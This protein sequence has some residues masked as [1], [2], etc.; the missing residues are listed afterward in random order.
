MP[1]WY[2]HLDVAKKAIAA[3]NEKGQYFDG[4]GPTPPSIQAIAEKNP[5][6]FALGAIGPD[7][8][9]MLPDFAPPNDWIRGTA[10]TIFAI[11]DWIDEYFIGPYEK[12][13]EP[14]MMSG[15]SELDAFTGGLWGT[16][17]S[18]YSDFSRNVTDLLITELASQYDL[19][20][21][22]GS[23]VP[24]G[25]DE[26]VYYWSDILHYR[27]TYTFGAHLWQKASAAKDSSL[28]AFALGWM[29][30]LAADVTGHCFVNEKCGGPYRL[31]WQ[32]H[33]LVENHMDATVY[34]HEHGTGNQYESLT[35]SALHLWINFDSSS[36]TN[37]FVSSGPSYPTGDDVNSM[38]ARQRAWDRDSSLPDV[39]AQFICQALLDVYLTSPTDPTALSKAAWA[40]HP[41][42]LPGDPPG[43]PAGFPTP[44]DLFDPSTGS[45]AYQYLYKYLKWTSTAQYR[46]PRPQPPAKYVIPEFPAFP[47]SGSSDPTLDGNWA[48]DVIAILLLL[49]AWALW[50][51]EVLLYPLA[52][53]AALIL[54]PLT[55]DLRRWI[56]D[57][58]QVPSYNLWLALHWFHSL[59]GYELP[60]NSEINPGLTTLG[61]SV[62][63]LEATL[64]A[65][66]DDPSG[67]LST[68]VPPTASE[69]SGRDLD[70]QF[71]R[72]AMTDPNTLVQ[73]IVAST[74]LGH[75]CSKLSES[76]S[77]FARPWQFPLSDNAGDTMPSELPLTVA[78][79]YRSGVDAT[80]LFA[81]QP[82][83]AA[84]RTTFE[85]AGSSAETDKAAGAFL[86][87]GQHLGDPV[88]YTCYL[89]GKLTRD[90]LDPESLAS[91]NLDSD[92]GYGY[93]CWDWVRSHY[94]T[95]TPSGYAGTHAHDYQAPQQPGY[96]WCADEL[97]PAAAPPPPGTPIPAS[98]DPTKPETPVGIRYIGKEVR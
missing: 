69:P 1:G 93:L 14:V 96:G 67:G 81:N 10:K 28:Q 30:H 78:S 52:V 26:K 98:H 53:G 86:P 49:L 46:F 20:G 13:I 37:F 38:L 39:L 87:H 29:T 16:I 6:Y 66:L 50:L 17:S 11:Y 89:I 32:R 63:D 47:G 95:G 72:D 48:H 59:T 70:T 5:A 56:Y 57:H 76:P 51:I 97:N 65:V 9:F 82:G 74:P 58:F 36:A 68:T 15:S 91:F 85:N 84:A 62:G 61:T 19:F 3:L 42:I 7:L 80:V 75:T 90:G 94:Y 35:E 8:F 60:M 77:E 31:H 24:K 44:G 55:F 4:A 73:S 18:I 33:H 27:K 2:I 21:L 54:D 34:Q 22:L 12:E 64:V 45:G 43:I 92:R 25:C 41:T 40:P 83:D 23:G 88:D 79:P 71:P